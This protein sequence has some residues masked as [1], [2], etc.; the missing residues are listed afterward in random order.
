[1]SA[2]LLAA[3]I[4]G[5]SPSQAAGQKRVDVS[6]QVSVLA[7]ALPRRD[8]AELRPQA[9]VELTARPSRTVRLKFDGFV[10]GLAADRSGQ[11]LGAIAGVREAWLEVAG[12][13]GD[14]RAGYG[15]IVW[16]RLDE[17]QPSDVINPLDTSRYLFDG[18]SAAR[19]PVAFLR[20]RVFASH[21][22]AIEGVAVPGFSRGKF[23]ELKEDTSPFNLVNDAVLP[24]AVPGGKTIVRD[25]PGLL[26]RNMSGGGRVSGTI[27]RVDI[28]G[29]VFRGF[30]AFGVTTF[31][32]IF[33]PAVAGHLVQRFP[34][35]TMVSADFETVVGEWALRG[36]AAFFVEKELPR[37]NGIG[38]VEG[39]ALDAGAGFDR[40]TGQYRVFALAILHREWSPQDPGI[41]R[42]DVDFVGS[43][44]RQFGRDRW[45]ARAFAV[46]N[47]ADASGFVRGLIV[48][49]AADNVAIEGSAAAF[50]GDGNDSLARF[51][52][53]DFLL[54]RVRWRF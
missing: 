49:R 48:W 6:G 29:G 47:P 16:G 36:E 25:E 40:R 43:I 20:G 53:R 27:G 34:R 26:L 9:A 46:V 12:T 1:M 39:K 33:G 5:Q 10:E 24:A 52:T 21:D 51:K 3:L 54:T 18:R 22:F 14:F 28:A 30:D 38:S 50:L 23:D 45:L 11:V 4:A 32:P 31:E 2:W 8:V 41:D 17:I 44:E 15:R 35:F 19:L 37:S 13:K 7:D 42:T